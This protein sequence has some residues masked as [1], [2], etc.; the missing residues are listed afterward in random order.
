LTGMSCVAAAKT[1]TLLGPL[2]LSGGRGSAQ[3]L[4]VTQPSRSAAPAQAT[5]TSAA[6]ATS[7]PRRRGCWRPRADG[8]VE[9]HLL[10][11]A[12]QRQRVDELAPV[13][14][15]PEL[16]RRHAVVGQAGRDPVPDG[17]ALGRRD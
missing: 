16:P 4:K 11:V 9:E 1:A 5:T 15:D 6:S 2:K 10:E 17:G 8:G 14:H 13:G 3:L 7:G 12:A